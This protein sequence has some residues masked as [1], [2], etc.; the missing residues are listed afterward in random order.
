VRRIFDR[1]AKTGSALSVVWELNAAGEVTTCRPCANGI[2]GGKL[3]FRKQ[4]AVLL[5]RN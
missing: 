3:G 4:S 5:D 1:F 2:R